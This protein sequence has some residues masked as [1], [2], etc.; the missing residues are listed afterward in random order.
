MI[1]SVDFIKTL[2]SICHTTGC[3]VSECTQFL[4]TVIYTL[5]HASVSYK[6]ET[7][8]TAFMTSV[9]SETVTWMEQSNA[10]V[11]GRTKHPDDT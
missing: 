2:K 5:K 3:I 10:V 6:I 9:M 8:N 4:H 1:I 11:E 7:L